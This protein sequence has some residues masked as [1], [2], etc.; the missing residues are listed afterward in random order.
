MVNGSGGNSLRL[1]SQDVL[2]LGDGT[3]N[4]WFKGP[5]AFRNGDALRIE[6]ESGDQLILSGGQWN[7]ID[8][9]N[10]PKGYDVFAVQVPSGSAYILV[11]EDI[12][13]TLS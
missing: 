9:H 13:V 6:G 7:E 11:Q 4:P 8:P 10:A 12:T 3:F 2:D 5:D 1:N